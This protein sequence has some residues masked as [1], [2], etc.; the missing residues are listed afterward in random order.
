MTQPVSRNRSQGLFVWQ[1]RTPVGS[2][3]WGF[4]H[5]TKAVWPGALVSGCWLTSPEAH[6]PT[7]CP[8]LNLAAPG[9]SILCQPRNY[10]SE[11]HSHT[12]AAGTQVEGQG[13]SVST[14]PASTSWPVGTRNRTALALADQN[15]T[16]HCSQPS[17]VCFNIHSLSAYALF[18]WC[19]HLG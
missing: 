8:G 6:I 17:L 18:L 9:L 2:G 5:S 16:A 4:Q 1:S 7:T 15:L 13:D 11:T 12:S 19:P 3:T 10:C 14:H